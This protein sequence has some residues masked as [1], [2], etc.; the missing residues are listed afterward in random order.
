MPIRDMNARRSRHKR[1][2]DGNSRVPFGAMSPLSSSS[3]ED[4]LM[5]AAGWSVCLVVPEGGTAN[6]MYI[7]GTYNRPYLSPSCIATRAAK[8]TTFTLLSHLHMLL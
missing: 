2:G 3:S 5:D 6:D 1:V 8:L 4:E 7:Q